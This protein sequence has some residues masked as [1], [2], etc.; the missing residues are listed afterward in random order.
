MADLSERLRA[1]ELVRT[2]LT[3]GRASFGNTIPLSALDTLADI[4][5]RYEAALRRIAEHRLSGMQTECSQ[6]ARDAL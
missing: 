3:H 2:W 1:I 5:E 6:I 4:I